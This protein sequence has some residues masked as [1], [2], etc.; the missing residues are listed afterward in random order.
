M[1]LPTNLPKNINMNTPGSTC[2]G[3][4]WWILQHNYFLW[5]NI[6]AETTLIPVLELCKWQQ[7]LTKKLL[8]FLLFFWTLLCFP[9][10]KN[11]N[12][13]LTSRSDVGCIIHTSLHKWIRETKYGYN[14]LKNY[15]E[16]TVRVNVCVG[17]IKIFSVNIK[18]NDLGN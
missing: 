3:S 7:W 5:L 6:W 14:I 11:K 8:Y 9:V 1:L 15:V 18:K 17:R 10:Q 2:T 4:A 13:L 12:T 16:T